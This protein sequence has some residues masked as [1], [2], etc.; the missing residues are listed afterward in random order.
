MKDG[1]KAYVGVYMDIFDAS[2]SVGSTL[3]SI[4][5]YWKTLS[6]GYDGGAERDRGIR[7]VRRDPLRGVG[8]PVLS[9]PPPFRARDHRA[10]WVLRRLDPRRCD[11]ES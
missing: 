2:K 4:P 1:W 6:S 8:V 9:L 11:P 7:G 5:G 10:V 3:L